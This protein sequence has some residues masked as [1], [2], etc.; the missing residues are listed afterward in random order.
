M[1]KTEWIKTE[2][3]QSVFNTV[4]K[5]ATMRCLLNTF[6]FFKGVLAGRCARSDAKEHR[7]EVKKS[8]EERSLFSSVSD[9]EGRATQGTQRGGM[10]KL[11]SDKKKKTYVHRSVVHHAAREGASGAMKN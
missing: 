8:G 4:V 1:N 2:Q 10:R 9:D 3:H 5:M 11:T 6:P 7:K